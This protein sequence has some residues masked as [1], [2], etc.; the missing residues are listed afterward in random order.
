MKYSIQL[1]KENLFLNSHSKR[2]QT[3]LAML[4]QFQ[5]KIFSSNFKPYYLIVCEVIALENF[6]HI[7][8]ICLEIFTVNFKFKKILH[9]TRNHQKMT[10]VLPIHLTYLHWRLI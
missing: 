2:S 4:K 3:L 7:P 5:E 1:S 8:N 9:C 6:L 10:S